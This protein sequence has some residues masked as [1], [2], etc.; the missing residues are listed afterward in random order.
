MNDR[1]GLVV[2]ENSIS[3]NQVGHD[4]IVGSQ[5]KIVVE[6]RSPDALIALL[7]RS[8]QLSEDD[9]EYRA[10]IEELDSFLQARPG[11]KIVG[12]EAKLKSGGRDD[13]IDDA[14]F[15]ANR[16]ARRL[17][18]TQMSPS[19]QALYLHCLSRINSA[20]CS[21]IQPLIRGGAQKQVVDAAV[22]QL[23]VEP[24]YEEITAVDSSL[25][26]QMIRGMLYF[27]TGKCHLQWE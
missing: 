20:F 21:Y 7:E 5:L 14:D 24:I 19:L 10:M 12:L 9:P 16:F 22:Y 23:V 11:R 8:R 25:T 1:R 18:R 4:L 3:E 13:L 6:K 17:A 27:L 26:T 2:S 15:L